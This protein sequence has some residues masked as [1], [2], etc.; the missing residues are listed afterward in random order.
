MFRL[1]KIEILNPEN[2]S[3]YVLT[4]EDL[5]ARYGG[6]V[7]EGVELK[8]ERYQNIHKVLKPG[9]QGDRFLFHIKWNT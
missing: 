3:D 4:D 1:T 9:K 2:A 6:S 8:R 5:K 7:P